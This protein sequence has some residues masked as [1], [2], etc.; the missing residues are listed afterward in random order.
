MGR[1]SPG[2]LHQV[3]C[4]KE[5]DEPFPQVMGGVS[6]VLPATA[7]ALCSLGGL[8]RSLPGWVLWLCLPLSASSLADPVI[9]NLKPLPTI[10]IWVVLGRAAWSLGVSWMTV[11]LSGLARATDRSPQL[12]VPGWR[13]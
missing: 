2:S 9:H 7:F 12:P 6:V 3:P 10:P 8:R 1:E 5:G 4:P 13:A 11:A